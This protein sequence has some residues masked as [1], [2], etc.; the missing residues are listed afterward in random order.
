MEQKVKIVQIN[1][2]GI[3]YLSPLTGSRGWYWGTDYTSGDLFEAEELYRDGHRIRRNRLIF[4]HYPDGEQ[5]SR[6]RPG[7]GSISA[8][9]PMTAGGW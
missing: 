4:V 1:T 3:A 5:R 2:G 6:L 7:K 8:C 9:P